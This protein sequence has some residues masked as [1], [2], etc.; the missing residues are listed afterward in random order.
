MA[1]DY[2]INRLLVDNDMKPPADVLLDKKYDK[3][4]NTDMVYDDMIKNAKQ[5]T[6]QCLA[7]M[8]ST[9]HFK[10]GEGQSEA[11][12]SET[13][14]K[15][16]TKIIA[17]ANACSK[18]RG[19]I[20][21]HFKELINQ[22]RN[23]KVDWRDKLYTLATEP[24]RDEHSWRRPNRRFIGKDLYLPSITKIDGLRKIIFAVD[25]SGSMNTDLLIDA[26]SE[27]VSVVEDCDVDELIIMDVDTDV[28]HIRRFSKDDLPDALEVV[29][30]GGTA[31]EPAFDWVIENDEDPAVLI[32]F[33]DL[34]GS[35]PQYE[36]DHPVIWVNYG[37]KDTLCPFGE[38]IDIE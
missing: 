26:W 34:Y 35:F 30:R 8:P 2:V 1:G 20:P 7:D 17:A 37:M 31:F 24:M 6:I 14:N 5:I 21:G 16:K 3:A 18:N 13:E 9:G 11:D 23:P 4:W 33:T 29:G 15:W 38:V 27:I 32:Y 12:K 36:P 10:D 22:I 28:N 25:T 19:T